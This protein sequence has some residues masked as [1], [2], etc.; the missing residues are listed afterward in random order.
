MDSARW[1]RLKR[2]FSIGFSRVFACVALA[3]IGQLS[4]GWAQSTFGAFVGTVRDPAGAV[5]ANATVSI[6]NNGT[7]AKRSE[8]TDQ[9]GAYVLANLEPGVYEIT[10][11]ASGFQRATF[12]DL[13]LQARQTI[14]VDGTLVLATQTQSVSV[15]AVAPEITT[16]VS[17][18]AET[19]TG[20]ELIDLP[21]AIVSRGAGSTSP[22]TTLTTQPG[23]ITDNSGN[24]SVSGSK[25]SMLSMS[26]DGISTMSPRSYAPIAELFPSFNTIAEIRVSE[27]NNSAEFGGISDITTISRGGTNSFHGGV[28]ENLQNTALNARN[29]FSSSKPE[30]DMNN[31][32][33]YL[34]GPLSI[35][36]LY[37]GHDRT[38]F[39]LS[40]E[41]LQLARQSVLVESVPSLA[42]RS[43][44]LSAYSK[45]ITGFP[46]NQIPATDISP[47]ASAALQYLY[48][49]PNTGAPNAI[50]NNYVTNFPTPISSNQGDMRLDQNINSQQSVFARFTYKRREVENAPSGSVFAGPTHAPEND[51]ALTV[52][53]NYVI[54]PHVI[55]EVRAGFSGSNSSS[56]FGISASSIVSQLGLGLPGTVPPGNEIPNFSITGFQSTGDGQSSYSRT[57]TR[58]VLDNLTWTKGQ[59]TLK[60]GGDYRYLTGYYNNNF[61]STRVGTYTFNDTVTS[62]L[63][64]NAFAGFLLGVPDQTNVATVTEADADGHTEHYAVFAQDDWKVT[65]RL[66]LNYGLRWEYHPMFVDSKDNTATFLQNYYSV[67]NGQTVHGAVVVPD[68]RINGLDQSFVQAIAPTPVL[69]ASQAGLPQTLRFSQKTDFAPRFG[70]AWRPFDDK[71]VIRGGYGK[72]IETLLGAILFSQWG[73]PTSYNALY[74]QTIVGGKPTLTFPYPFPATLAQPGTAQLLAGADPHYRDP[75]VQQWNF[76]IERDLGFQTGLRISYDGSHGSQLGYY[77]DADQVPANTVGFAVASQGEPYPAWS[78]VKMAINGARSNY[79]ALT[80]SVNKRLSKGLQFQTSYVFAKNLSNQAGYDPTGFTGENG[81]VAT[82]QFNP[83]L[84]YGNVAFTRRNRFQTTFLYDLPFGHGRSFLGNANTVL[85]RI[86]GGWELAGVLLFQTGP[87]LTVTVANADPAGNNFDNTIG[88]GGGGGGG[89]RADIVSGVSVVP[90]NQRAGAWI[91][92]AAFAVPP[93]NIGRD[94]DSPIGSV[95][96]P[97]TQ[98][99]STSLF[100]SIQFTERARLQV[101][102]AAANLLNHLNLGTPNTNFNTAAFGTIT[103]TQSLEGAAPRSIQL[104]ARFT[105]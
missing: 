73:I 77:I 70:F 45:A 96:G 36:G 92:P 58:Q 88:T 85:D 48:P 3:A 71:T 65:P 99:V 79:D 61:G 39:F 64:G 35:P 23:V 15:V 67:V 18:L 72:Y 54:T 25:P 81:G 102:V 17:N 47:V 84:D 44:N 68:G 11:E 103:S 31:Y 62:S 97:G 52:A 101:G 27:V 55:N 19:K 66:T 49:L 80:T 94:P 93:N 12:K 56:Y 100:K 26:V 50:A 7:A 59:H 86:V 24:L 6:V 37:N 30:L 4:T 57:S 82:D 22:I 104:A 87:F 98:S 105:F 2:V 46:G 43:G 8:V 76:T 9:S 33:G 28:F 91:N 78:Y 32:G 41:G 40:Y 14:R 42:L 13:D 53:H 63:I 38:F 16:E 90:A 5:V 34:G 29:P 95:V 75:Y 51:F 10:V 21:I 20:R 60:F 89:G 1:Q 83:N 74:S 69:T